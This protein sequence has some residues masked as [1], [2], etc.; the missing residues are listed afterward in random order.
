MCRKLPP[1]IRILRKVTL[2]LTI[3]K[4]YTSFQKLKITCTHH[5]NTK[6]TV[7]QSTHVQLFPTTSVSIFL[8][9]ETGFLHFRLPHNRIFVCKMPI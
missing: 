8:P 3:Q 9:V 7:L 6:K 1:K 2:L 4:N 5:K